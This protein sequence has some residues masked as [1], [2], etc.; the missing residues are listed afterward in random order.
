MSLRVAETITLGGMTDLHVHARDFGQAEKEDFET[1]TK[2]AL[3]GGVD[4]IGAMPNYEPKFVVR[5]YSLQNMRALHARARGRIYSD[6]GMWAVAQPEF[7]N[8]GELEHMLPLSIGT[9]VYIEPTQ[10]NDTHYDVLDFLPIARRHHELEPNKLFAAHAE[11]DTIEDAI[12]YIAGDIGQ[13]LY[14]P[15]VNNRFVLEAIMK[16]KGSG[17]PVFAEVGPHH[18]LMTEENVRLLGWFA[19]MKPPL[20]TQED[21]DF[22]WA[23]L[24]SIDTIGTDHA[25]HIRSEKIEAQR[26]NPE[27]LTGSEYKKCYGVPGLDT[28]LPLLLHEIIY[29]Y[30]GQPRLTFNQLHRLTITNPRQLIGLSASSHASLTINTETYELMPQHVRSKC[31]WSPYEG[32]PVTGRVERVVRNGATLFENGTFAPPQGKV[33]QEAQSE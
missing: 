24:K 19:R 28:T 17:L 32:W 27:G 3:A 33:L 23:N 10:G 20:A 2:A 25:P 12:G 6:V 30:R 22:L 18:L 14:I 31:G 15:H 16:A 1:C 5:P 29:G 8:V 4:T 26:Q 21:Q 13:R 11:D 9:K 7:D